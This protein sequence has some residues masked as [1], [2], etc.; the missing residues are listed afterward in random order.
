[1]G[2]P[3][4][5]SGKR[6]FKSRDICRKYST[7][8]AAFLT[9]EAAAAG[10]RVGSRCEGIREARG[11]VSAH[12]ARRRPAARTCA[13]DRVEWWETSRGVTARTH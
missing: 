7:I 3:T 9:D 13:P 5:C 12:F 11:N 6:G 8:E 2:T 10:G 1:M 4:V